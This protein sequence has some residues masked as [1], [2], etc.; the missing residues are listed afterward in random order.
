MK[1]IN[2]NGG[3]EAPNVFS[4]FAYPFDTIIGMETVFGH[5]TSDIEYQNASLTHSGLEY[6]HFD[7]RDATCDTVYSAITN[8]TLTSEMEID[9]DIYY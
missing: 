4:V 7:L 5:N 2:E 3:R 1:D 8:H 9:Y 6:T